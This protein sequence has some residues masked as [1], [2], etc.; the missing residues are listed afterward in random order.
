[1]AHCQGRAPR[2]APQLDDGRPCRVHKL[3][4]RHE[5]RHDERKRHC[6]RHSGRHDNNV[7]CEVVPLLPP[8][9]GIHILGQHV[10][11]DDE[12]K[13]EDSHQSEPKRLGDRVVDIALEG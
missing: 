6:N 5:D 4:K 3:L 2:C 10:H 9:E 7:E 8:K 12:G 1:M 13:E 11:L